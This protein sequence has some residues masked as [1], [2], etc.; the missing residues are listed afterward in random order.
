MGRRFISEASINRLCAHDLLACSPFGTARLGGWLSWYS[1]AMVLRDR[2]KG[3]KHGSET[4]ELTDG[5]G[6]S[7]DTIEH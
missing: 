5:T 6:M 2:F 7:S 1:V 3:E 4:G